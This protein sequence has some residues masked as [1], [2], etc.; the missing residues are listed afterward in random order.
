MT[1]GNEMAYRDLREYIAALDSAGELV[2]VEAEVD[3]NLE[4]GAISRKAL[5]LRSGAPFFKK[6][7]G[8]SDEYRI[9]ANPIGPSR[10]NLY[11]RFAL[12]LGLSPELSPLDMIEEFSRITKNLLGPKR[13]SNA[14]CK[15]NIATGDKINLLKFPVPKVHEPDGGRYIGTWHVDVTKDRDTGFV[16]WGMYRHMVIDERTMGWL[17]EPAQHGS[18]H[19][20]TYIA[21]GERMPLAIAIGTEPVTSIIAGTQ[22]PTGISE[23][24]VIGGIRGM[25]IETIPCETVDLEVPASAEI[26]LEGYVEPN[27][28]AVEGP[29]G[30]FTGYVGHEKRGPVFHVTAV[31]HRNNPILTMSNMGKPWDDYAV[32][33]SI[34]MSSYIAKELRER[35][36]PFRAVYI[37]PPILAVIVSVKSPYAGFIHKLASTIWASKAAVYRPYI[38]VVGEDVDIFNAE[39]VFWCLTTRLHPK[40]GINIIEHTAAMP[41][42]P[43]LWPEERKTLTTPRVVFNA[44]FP[45]EWPREAV[46]GIVDYQHAWPDGI[47]KKVD[48]SWKDYGFK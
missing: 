46:P 38:F 6:L 42:L 39:E 15:E 8:Y 13:V 30:E 7:K 23:P 48:A 3:W 16:N 14:P 33:S 27:E 21:R 45:E 29:F 40:R 36:V 41:L 20:R 26:V 1:G 22:V 9:L 2:S 31:T 44:T 18:G 47:R 10:P 34:T 35:E 4:A 24:D 11:K 12:A 37:P 19:Y 43:Y 17:A 5:D 25:P 32:M 28:R